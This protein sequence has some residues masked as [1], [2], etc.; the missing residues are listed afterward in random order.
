MQVPSIVY[1]PKKADI[2]DLKRAAD[3]GGLID[4][5]DNPDDEVVQKAID[6]LRELPDQS[7]VPL[8]NVAARRRGN[9]GLR[10]GAIEA[11]GA[12]GERS[13]LLTLER[14][15]HTDEN[16]ECRWAAALAIGVTGDSGAIPSLVRALDDPSKYVRYGAATAL[17][18]IGWTPSDDGEKIRYLIARQDWD[19][20]MRLRNAPVKP[21]VRAARDFDPSVRIAALRTL[22]EMERAD[23][24]L[25]CS[26]ALRDRDDRVR[27]QASL[28]LPRCGI[29]RLHLPIT[30]S[31]WPRSKD[32]RVAALLNFLFLGLGYNYLGKWWGLLFFTI[33]STLNLVYLDYTGGNLP[34][35]VI[36]LFSFPYSIPFAVHAWHVGAKMEV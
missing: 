15:L 2:G 12:I 5:L 18:Q 21:L 1:P 8:E 13:A 14:V 11:L 23:A 10:L 25:A 36:P 7:V 6:A 24:G 34:L 26:A 31:R 32:P 33:F 20:A 17:E 4:L 29:T 9:L 3:V 30:L 35:M 22:G 28:A 19:A 27:W 16:M